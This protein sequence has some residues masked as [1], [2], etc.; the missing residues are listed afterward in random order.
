[1]KHK[2]L[3]LP[4]ALLA[5]AA[6]T[7]A[8][9]SFAASSASSAIFESLSTSVG[10]ASASLR[11][12]SDSSSEDKKVSDGDYRIEG[13]EPVAGQPDR[14]RLVLRALDEHDG[15]D[16]LSLELPRQVVAD[17]ALGNGSVVGARRRPYGVQ[18]DISATRQVFFLVLDDIWFRELSTRPVS[19]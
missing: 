9:A 10:S 2:T 15:D 8:P 4:A 19:L 6:A 18:F 13:V 7:F 14:V 1:M 17:A 16:L 5:L 12:S 3:R 11:R